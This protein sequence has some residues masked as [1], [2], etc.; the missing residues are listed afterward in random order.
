M[1][2]IA[3]ATLSIFCTIATS[4]A[5]DAYGPINDNARGIIQIARMTHKFKRGLMHFNVMGNTSATIRNIYFV[6]HTKLV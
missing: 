4:L 2:S 1:F 6:P 5:I 3:V